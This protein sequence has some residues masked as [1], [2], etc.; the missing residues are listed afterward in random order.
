MGTIKEH[1]N[2]SSPYPIPMERYV[3]TVKEMDADDQPREKAEKLGCHVL[4]TP[5]LWAIILRT[6]T[7]GYPITELCRDL[8]RMNDGSLHKLERRT[9]N[10]IMELK[11]IGI[12]KCI[13]IEAVL[14]IIKRYCSEQI[15]S[16]DPIRH[17]AQIYERMKPFIGNLDHE[18][19]WLLLLNRRNQIIKQI[20]LTSGTSN[21]SIF[22][23]RK[24]IKLALLE[25]AESMILCHNH[26]SN[27]LNPSPQDDKL[28][29]DLNLACK[30]MN[31]KLLDHVI[32]TSKGYY[33][34][35]DNEKL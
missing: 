25:N 33:S 26:P 2:Q 5:E 14:E 28:T 11:G 32:V 4:T 24:A 16:D 9:R 21:A 17:S 1:N 10:E 12:T 20:P 19:I 18:E 7:P 35:R 30:Y 8:M 34:Y 22:D 29:S 13:Q 27:S 23:Q 6:G 15:P 3:R 31:L